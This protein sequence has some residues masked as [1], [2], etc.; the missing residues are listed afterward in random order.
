MYLR[1]GRDSFDVWRASIDHLYDVT[2]P[3]DLELHTFYG[4][5][6]G[7]HFGDS[8]L[9]S[10][11]SVAQSLV[12]SNAHVRRS[13]DHVMI[14]F[15]QS[16]LHTGDYDGRS[17]M[18]ESGDIGFI[19]FGRSASSDDVAFQRITLLLPR[20]RLSKSMRARNL[21]GLVLGRERSITDILGRYLT[22][23]FQTADQLTQAQ[24]SAA[25]DAMFVLLDGSWDDQDIALP[26]GEETPS[27]VFRKMVATHVDQNLMRPDLSADSIAASL[28][29]SRSKLYAL[30]EPEGGVRNFVIA[31][32]LDRSLAFLLKNADQAGSIGNVARMNCFK[33]ESH[34]SRAFH[35]RFGISPRDVRRLVTARSTPSSYRHDRSAP[36]TISDWVRK[37]RGR[38]ERAL[39]L[40]RDAAGHL[41]RREAGVL[42]DDGDDRNADFRENIDRGPQG[43]QGANNQ[44]QKC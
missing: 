11:A 35:R 32:R 12:R 10:N 44:D 42:P 39:E 25:I 8:L 7:F 20:E 9:F 34:F 19:D 2:L 16:G 43:G 31:R 17:M 23:L 33:S 15:Q 13:I 24:A 1:Q 22:A 28:R 41:V 18:L 40:C 6:S 29:M 27:Q 36:V 5:V 4:A 21:H 14:K 37:L 30:M 26:Q 3:D 38:G